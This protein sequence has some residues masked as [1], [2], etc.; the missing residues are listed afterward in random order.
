MKTVILFAIPVTLLVASSP[1]VFA[2]PKEISHEEFYK[3]L[4]E[5]YAKVSKL[6]RRQMQEIASTRDGKRYEEK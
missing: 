3:P 6:P 4:R 5:Q 2:Q 1:M